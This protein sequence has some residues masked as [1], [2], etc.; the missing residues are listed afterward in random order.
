MFSSR[1]VKTVQRYPL[2][3]ASRTSRA[4]SWIW[5]FSGVPVHLVRGGKNLGEADIPHHGLLSRIGNNL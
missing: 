5:T 2:S 3:N 4:R 1:L